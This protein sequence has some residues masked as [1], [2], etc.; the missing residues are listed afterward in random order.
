[1]QPLTGK[2]FTLDSVAW[3][4]ADGVLHIGNAISIVGATTAREQGAVVTAVFEMK[5]GLDMKA[6]GGMFRYV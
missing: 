4:L 5:F 1:M 3:A 2:G 6:F